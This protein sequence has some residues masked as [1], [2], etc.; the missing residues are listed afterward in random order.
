MKILIDGRMSGLV[1]AGIGRYA[2]NLLRNLFSLDNKNDCTVLVRNTY[3]EGLPNSRAKI[4]KTDIPHYSLE[5]QIKLPFIIGRE[6]PDLVHFLHFN[7][8]ILYFGKYIVT[9][10][11]LIKH[12]SRG[13]ETTTKNQGL[14]WFKYLGYKFIFN[15]AVKRAG[16]IIVPSQFVKEELLKNYSLDKDKITVIYEGVDKKFSKVKTDTK[17]L[18][19]YGLSSRYII[20]T[21]S[22]YPHKNVEKLLEALVLLNSQRN[23][24]FHLAIVCARSVFSQRFSEKIHQY[25][26]EK[27][28]H[29]LGFVS[30]EE[31]I[32]LY[33]SAQAFV[34]PTFSEG[35]GLPGL[36]AMACGCPVICSDIPV[37]HE[38][39][40]GAALYFNPH[41]SLDIATKVR[42][43]L[44]YSLQKKE[45]LVGKGYGLVKNYSWEKMTK[46]IISVY[47]SFN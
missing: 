47:E 25:K 8:P 41:D 3:P 4:I 22:L 23:L 40:Q 29:L 36:E 26:L 37:L 33:S 7:V 31:L 1:H 38:I 44:N 24:D 14:Y 28:V 12:V 11:D 5:E 13:K 19:K 30:D 9:I 43:C 16:K 42:E 6:R 17:I 20:Y 21:G 15:M 35:F 2:E 45:N 18:K 32:S 46:E 10:H 27:Y 39:Y 34:F